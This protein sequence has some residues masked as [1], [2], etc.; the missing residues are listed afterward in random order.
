LRT[1]RGSLLLE[2]LTDLLDALRGH[3]DSLIGDRV[4]AVLA[5]ELTGVVGKHVGVSQDGFIS[6]VLIGELLKKFTSLDELLVGLD[7][8][9]LNLAGIVVQNLGDIRTEVVNDLKTCFAYSVGAE[10]VRADL[11][12]G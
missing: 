10:L 1:G 9:I 2:L 8:S 7:Q 12:R 5:E 6:L 11:Q 4:R 3:G